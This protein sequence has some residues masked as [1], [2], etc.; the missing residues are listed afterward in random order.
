MSLQKRKE[1]PG[2][3]HHAI[4]TVAAA[5][6]MT[7]VHANYIAQA[8]VFAHRQGKLNQGLGVYEA[9]DIVIGAG[10]MDVTAVPEVV[11]ED[12]A[13]AVVDGNRSSGYYTLNVMADTAIA[14]AREMGISMVF[15]GNHNDAGS[16]AAYVYK[17][18]T[19]DMVG[20]ASNNT[21]PLAAPFGAMVNVLSCPPFDAIMPG[22]VEAP[23]WTST[24]FAEFYDADIAEA[25]LGNKPMDGKWLIDPETGELSDDASAYA[26]PIPGYGRV[27]D[28]AC[29]GQIEHPRTYAMNLWNEGLTAIVNPLGIPSS[30]MP[31][32]EDY[33]AGAAG[34]SVGGSYYLCIDPSVFGS[35]AAVKDR[36]DAFVASIKSA[37]P[38]PGHSVRLPGEPGYH[39]LESDADEVEV[40]DTHWRAF[41]DTIAARY[42]LDEDGLRA[43]YEEDT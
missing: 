14:K 35:I 22:G 31:T 13:W 21:V 24:K 23:I 6:G 41:F 33:A 19:E 34:P 28:A 43:S 7:P 30:Q 1:N 32:I 3:L 2:F 29:A 16:F 4:A 42:G 18:Y 17:A 15:G 5:A 9:I 36:S 38:R 20:I 40:F 39:A 26:E 37:K 27:W 25:V 11:N 8:I 10:A 12:A